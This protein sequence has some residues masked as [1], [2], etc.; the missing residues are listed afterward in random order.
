MDW[1]VLVNA[2]ITFERV[3]PVI[4]VLDV[5]AALD[6]YQRLGFSIESYEGGARYGFVER[7]HVSL[8]ITEW[9]E[10]EPKRT[11]AHVYL[12]VSDADAVHAEWARSG[13]EGRLGDLHD[14]EYGLREFGFVDAD[15]T[16]HRVGSPLASVGPESS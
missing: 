16:L 13:V 1:G 3:A 14:T 2:S 4:P 8:H 9:S 5:D 11:G 6:R 12:Y 15:G 7:D 10:H